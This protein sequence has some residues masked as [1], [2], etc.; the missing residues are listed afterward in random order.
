MR[1]ARL[2]RRVSAELPARHRGDL[3]QQLWRATL[4]IPTNIAEGYG[5]DSRGDYIRFLRI[6]NGSLKEAETLLQLCQDLAPP[7]A[8]RVAEALEEADQLGRMLG[9]MIRR[10]SRGP[11]SSGWRSPNT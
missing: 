6:A 10:L 11:G 5:R 2:A 3:A 7:D 9:A 4:S 8:V 1:L